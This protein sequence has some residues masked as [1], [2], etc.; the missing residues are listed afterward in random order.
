MA[1]LVPLV[2][3]LMM[4]VAACSEHAPPANP[5]V[6]ADLTQLTPE[7]WQ[8]LSERAIYF[9]HQSVGGNVVD[10]IRALA[11]ENAQ[12]AKL[13]VVSGSG[14]STAPGL[15]EFPIGENGDPVTKNAAFLGATEGTLGPKPV[16][17]FKYCFA[18]V[19]EN[20]DARAL[21]DRYQQTVAALRA[22]QPGAIIVHVTAP[23]TTD[24]QFRNWVNTLRGRPNRR[25]WNGIRSRYNEILRAAYSGKEPIFDL[26]AVES[27][28]SDGTGVY[29]SVGG[30]RVYA[31]ADE[32]TSDG[33]HLNSAGSKH[34]AVE[35]LLTLA[36]LPGA[37]SHRIADAAR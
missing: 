32:W 10:G 36:S 35:L 8:L 4:A 20:T 3:A 33:S 28:R 11:A 12:I 17:M 27:T 5:R 23:L 9:G 25:T 19:D 30:E 6:T 34:A 31:M 21:F 15:R 24:S 26:A 37:S 22:K 14:A 29:A 18:D 7:Q 16:L 2:V 1:R 13:R